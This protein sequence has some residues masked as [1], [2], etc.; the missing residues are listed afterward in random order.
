VTFTA[1][2]RAEKDISSNLDLDRFAERIR[3]STSDKAFDTLLAEVRARPDGGR[4]ILRALMRH[5]SSQANFWAAGVARSELGAG[6]VPLLTEM[7][8][9]RR[10]FTRDI[11]MQELAAIDVDLLRPFIP[12]MRRTLLR[13]KPPAAL[14]SPGG[15]AMW[16][17][18]RL[19][20]RESAAVFRA[21]AEKQEHGRFYTYRMPLVLADYL[22]DPGSLLRRI[23]SHDH[24]WMLWLVMAAAQLDVP[25]IDEALATGASDLPDEECRAICGRQ[26]SNLPR[27]RSV[28]S[29]HGRSSESSS[30]IQRR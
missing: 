8:Q 11:A 30:D 7:A 19:R 6:A 13:S 12:A 1:A 20:D 28:S 15:A 2:E 9:D 3:R 16:R 4:S 29:S 26:L 17:L 14:S 24:D 5:G 23:E 25:G 10:T 27:V 22:D 21:F 18:V